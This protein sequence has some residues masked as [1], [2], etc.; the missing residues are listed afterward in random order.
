MQFYSHLSLPVASVLSKELKA[1]LQPKKLSLISLLDPN[2]IY[3]DADGTL[4]PPSP[5]D[6]QPSPALTSTASSDATLEVFK[7][8]L[9]S[10]EN[11]PTHRAPFESRAASKRLRL[12]KQ[13]E[14]VLEARK[15]DL[16]EKAFEEW[17]DVDGEMVPKAKDAVRALLFSLAAILTTFEGLRAVCA[18]RQRGLMQ[19]GLG[20]QQ[21]LPPERSGHRLPKLLLGGPK[22]QLRKHG[23]G[24]RRV[25]DNPRVRAGMFDS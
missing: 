11:R 16:V 18:R 15:I 5:T 8:S 21:S 13:K 10:A 1:L 3:M 9:P 6:R 19:A 17:D 12:D 20:V 2:D 25:A 4:D 14:V 7:I 23:V 22:L 24:H